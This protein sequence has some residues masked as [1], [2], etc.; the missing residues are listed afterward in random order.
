MEE[1][2]IR[3]VV[4]WNHSVPSTLDGTFSLLFHEKNCFD[5]KTKNKQ[6]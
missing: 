2:R 1:A 3:E 6:K 4:S 5:E